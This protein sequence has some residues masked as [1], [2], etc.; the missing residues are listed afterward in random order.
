MALRF[1]IIVVIIVGVILIKENRPKKQKPVVINESQV[2]P[3]VVQPAVEKEPEPF[4]TEVKQ[5]SET[6]PAAE[7]EPVTQ[8]TITPEPE[9]II[10]PEVTPPPVQ[11][12]QEPVVPKAVKKPAPSFTPYPKNEILSAEDKIIDLRE[13]VPEIQED[14]QEVY[15]DKIFSQKYGPDKVSDLTIDAV[16]YLTNPEEFEKNN[17]RDVIA[18]TKEFLLNV[19]KIRKKYEVRR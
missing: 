15:K 10:V 13:T 9:P 16:L 12:F 6:S 7:V 3:P 14:L 2:T 18:N 1:L 17:P 11:T 5:E 4:V 8:P 19:Q